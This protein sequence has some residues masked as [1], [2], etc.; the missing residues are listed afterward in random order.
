MP[1]RKEIEMVTEDSK[2]TSRISRTKGYYGWAR[3]L[4]LNI[5]DSET[6]VGK[7]YE[8]KIKKLLEQKGYSVKKMAQNY[9]FDLLINNNIKVDVKVGHPYNS[10][11]NSRYHT[12]NL[13]KQYASCDLYII[14]CLD[15]NDFIEKTL[16]IP[17]NILKVTQLSIGKYSAYDKFVDCF[18]YIDKYDYFY[19]TLSE[20]VSK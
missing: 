2:L 15:E 4:D 3:E 16:I 13:Y 14:I 19:K 12:F 18:D 10:D 1:T 17:S 11:N 5:K 6:T 8:Y 9:P 7:Q 20:M